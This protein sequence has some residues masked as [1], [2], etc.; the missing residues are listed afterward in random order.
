[1]T[2]KPYLRYKEAGVKWMGKVPEH[3]E[4]KPLKRIGKINYGI[5]EPPKYQSEGTPL[6]RA[7][8]IHEG[9]LIEDGMVFV[10]HE[11]IPAN[12]VFWLQ[13]GDIIIV[14]SGAYTG[15]SARIPNG[16]VK[17]I[18]GFDMVLRCYED[19]SKFVQYALLSKYLKQ[20]QIDLEKLRAAQP[21]LNA[22]ELGSCLFIAPPLSEQQ[23]IVSFL[24]QE[25]SRIDTL[26]S[27]K[28]RLLSL[29]Q[30]YRQALISNAVTKG[31]DPSVKMKDSGVEWLGEVPEHWEVMRLGFLCNKIGSGKT[32]LGGSESYSES[33]VLFI[34]SQN[35]YY[36]GL[37]LDD[38]V[39]INEEID[40]EMAGSR[41][42]PGDV[43][44]NI[45]G[46]SLG[47]TCLVP[48]NFPPANVNQHVSI[49][50]AKDSSIR[51]FLSWAMKSFSIKAQIESYQNGAA[52][53]GLNFD[54]IS[55]LIIV[56]PP[57]I[58]YSYI[59][60][61]LDHETSRIDTLISQ[62][63]KFIDLLKEY[64]SSLITAAVTG[65][66]DVREV[67]PSGSEKQEIAYE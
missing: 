9:K 43:L 7:T 21:H 28:E 1:M 3:W 46:A 12:R 11:D 56:V 49:I 18:A 57:R 67:V 47:R 50:R 4:I 61:F 13:V 24:D 29:L 42:L 26:I 48:E 33:G 38:I 40:G 22:E 32:P 8:N 5:G 60:G 16:Y 52:R 58:E 66:I 39:C 59:S 64:R 31:L 65:K 36:E 6:I 10:N 2:H 20:D 19:D 34:R 41:V 45:T 23:T 30:E 15:D 51:K 55:Q 37:L 62:A 14:R 25:T 35:V 54:Q 17:S 63:R 27:E 53:E 44:L